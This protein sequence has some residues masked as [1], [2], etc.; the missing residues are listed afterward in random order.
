MTGRI[1][2]ARAASLLVRLR[3]R[4]V[5]NRL[6]ARPQKT[7]LPGARRATPGKS[8]NVW[9]TALA[10]A[11]FPVIVFRTVSMVLDAIARHEG[12][13]AAAGLTGGRGAHMLPVLAAELAVVMAAVL[14]ASMMTR[15]LTSPEWD[16]E[17]LVTL[18]I[19]RPTLMAV[20]ILERTVVNP[21]GLLLIWPYATVI[22]WR[23]G[24]RLAAPLLAAACALPLLA[25]VAASWVLAEAGLR[26]RLSAPR[27][28][29]AQAVVTVLSLA[30]FFVAYSPETGSGRV[31][32]RMAA[33]LAPVWRWSPPGLAIAAL[34]PPTPFGWRSISWRSRSRRASRSRSAWQ[35]FATC[36]GT[37]WSRAGVAKAGASP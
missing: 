7:T 17:W 25:L 19:P 26:V 13:A 21:V 4:R 18:P 2:A 24:L 30:A 8:R 10:G 16:L 6:F 5:R 23:G 28:R 15:E 34:T 22:A 32:Y 3:W 11:Y 20:R 36:C 12:Y 14:L 27:L 33:A 31:V 9:L 37:A 29:N 35:R 1:T